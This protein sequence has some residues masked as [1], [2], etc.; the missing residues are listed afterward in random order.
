L[1]EESKNCSRLDI[2]NRINK[3]FR[4]SPQLQ[5]INRNQA[6]LMSFI[7]DEKGNIHSI[8]ALQATS[9]AMAEDCKKAI[10]RLPRMNPAL[11]QGR[12]VSLQM[13]IPI[14]V[15]FSN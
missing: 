11:Q 12:P 5:D 9:K 4:V 13:E 14:R 2:V 1:G 6:A 3:Q 8:K 15:S 10:E 7:V